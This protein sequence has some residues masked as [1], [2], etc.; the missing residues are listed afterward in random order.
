MIAVMPAL[1]S[2]SGDCGHFKQIVVTYNRFQ[3]LAFWRYAVS[4]ISGVA[5][6]Y[7]GEILL[8]LELWDELE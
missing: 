1:L 2:S 3:C 6:A 5:V 7:K 4:E 8:A